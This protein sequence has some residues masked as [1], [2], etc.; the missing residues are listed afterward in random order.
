MEMKD[1]WQVPARASICSLQ[2][3]ETRIIELAF[4]EKRRKEAYR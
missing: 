1:A 3:S 4:E 2:C